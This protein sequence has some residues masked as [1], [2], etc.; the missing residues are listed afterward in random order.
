[1]RYLLFLV[2]AAIFLHAFLFVPPFVPIGFLSDVDGLIYAVDGKRMCA[3]EIMYRDFFQ[4]STPGTSFVYAVLIRVFGLR[5]WI[6]NL[7]LLVVGVG[8]AWVGVV[9]A[10]KLVRPSLAL[11]PSAL[12]LVGIYT[13]ELDPTHHWLS[14]LA[15][16]VSIGALMERRTPARIV[17]AGAFAGLATCFTQSRGLSL[18]AGLGAFLWWESWC[19]RGIGRELFKKE[20]YLAA[21]FFTTIVAGNAYFAW[22]AGLARFLW[23]T[24]TFGIRYYPKDIHN[25]TFRVIPENMAY[26]PG[27]LVSAPGT[28]LCWFFMYVG[29]PLIYILF[30]VRYWRGLRSHPTEYWARPMLLAMVG[31]SMLLSIAFAPSDTRVAACSLPGTILIIWFTDSLSLVGRKLSAFLAGVVFLIAPFAV[32]ASQSSHWVLFPTING[33]IA[34]SDPHVY[35]EYRWIQEHTRSEEYLEGAPTEAYFN[36]DIR[37]PSPL[38]FL[39][40][41]GYTTT[42]QVGDVI[43]SLHQRQV[44]YVFWTSP[45]LDTLSPLHT[46]EEHLGPLRKY[47]RT[48]YRMVKTF[49]NSDEVWQWKN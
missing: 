26:V 13:N 48:H 29:V 7:M 39:T 17:A 16:T 41:N 11:L 46:S 18:V 1:M 25:N 27:M 47:V 2:A 10:K 33:N 4:F 21:A 31:C 32:V 22:K 38:I 30:F 42:E 49:A 14:L 35:E 28:L 20:A 23:C 37:N 9:I 24:V 45:G 43:Q 15:G 40:D 19:K 34:I 6:P 5:L 36:L 12:F 44:R 3:G 8:L